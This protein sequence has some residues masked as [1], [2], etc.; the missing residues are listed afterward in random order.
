VSPGGQASTPGFI[1]EAWSNRSRERLQKK[2][3]IAVLNAP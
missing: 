2:G 3:T 1:L